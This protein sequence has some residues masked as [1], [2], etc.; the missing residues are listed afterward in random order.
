MECDEPRKRVLIMKE[1]HRRVPA[2]GAYDAPKRVGLR[3]DEWIELTRCIKFSSS[4]ATA[5]RWPGP[6]NS[7]DF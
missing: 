4:G 1:E 6:P 7:W 5:Q 3:T 2:V